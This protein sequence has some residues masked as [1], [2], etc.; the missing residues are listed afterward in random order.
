MLNKMIARVPEGAG[1]GLACMGDVT[2]CSAGW[3]QDRA[4]V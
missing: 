1:T 3:H 4:E 2:G